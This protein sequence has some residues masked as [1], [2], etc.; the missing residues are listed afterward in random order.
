MLTFYLDVTQRAE[1]LV[2]G[3]CRAHSHVSPNSTPRLPVQTLIKRFLSPRGR[4]TPMTMVDVY[5]L[6][7]HRAEM[8]ISSGEPL[9]RWII[10]TKT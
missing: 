7:Q 3:G 4:R 10:G 6:H 2:I 9:K 8:F 1:G 5:L